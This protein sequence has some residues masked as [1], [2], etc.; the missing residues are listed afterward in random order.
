M[1]K[2]KVMLVA[3]TLVGI[4]G[5]TFASKIAKMYSIDFCTAPCFNGTCGIVGGE[6]TTCDVFIND[7]RYTNDILQP[8]ICTTTP[9]AG[10]LLENKC[11]VSP[12]GAFKL[13]TTQ[14][15]TRTTDEDLE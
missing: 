6:R 10:G 15:C 14:P 1:K 9:N 11:K 7:A 2:V 3:I 8:L 4:A 13:C 12:G 5:G